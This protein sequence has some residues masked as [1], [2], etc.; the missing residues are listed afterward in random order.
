VRALTDKEYGLILGMIAN[1]PTLNNQQILAYFT[2]PGRD[3]NHRVIGTLRG[4][5]TRPGVG[6]ATATEVELYMKSV[7]R[8]WALFPILGRHQAGASLPRLLLN[9]WP[10]GQGLFSSGAVVTGAGQ[11]LNWTYDCGTSSEKGLLT[12]ALDAFKIQQVACGASSI[13]LHVLSHFD[14]DHIS[15]IIDLLDRLSIKTLLLPYIPL[16]QRLLVAL[17]FG[18]GADD[19]FLDFF[20]D[21]VAWLSNRGGGRIEEIVFVPS[22]GPDDD[23]PSSPE[24]TGIGPGE[25]GFDGRVGDLKVEVGGIPEGAAGDPAVAPQIVGVRVRFLKPGGR[26]IAPHFWE[27]VPYNDATLAIRVTP[28]FLATVLPLI[29]ELRT[30]PE[31]R[32]TALEALKATYDRH[33]GKSSV[34]R[35]KIS[36]FMYSGPLGRRLQL[37]GGACLSLPMGTTDF[38]QM[39]T[40]DG[41][42]N[43]IARY[44]AF[45][46]FY[47]SGERL[48]RAS[49]FQVMHHGALGSWHTGL[50]AK[51]APRISIFSSDPDHPRYR[52][53]HKDV[54]R[55]FWNYGATQVDRING[56]ALQRHLIAS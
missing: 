13:R 43:D 44:G 48:K 31:R 24:G 55:D 4:G 41:L 5:G 18:I 10:V 17:D 49:L 26:L 52:H 50:A 2:R 27:F 6:R 56:Y 39:Y 36:L 12:G 40:G 21:P 16:W 51:V 3:L 47:N 35:N 7:E 20:I 14:K 53:P 37:G 22:L 29:D 8:F 38:A 23:L 30:Q 25:D 46:K 19:E 28:M 54:L 15:G 42:L 1:Q 34:A 33:F 9:W 32:A 45:E 11:P